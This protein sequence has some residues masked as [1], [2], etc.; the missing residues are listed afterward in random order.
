MER[1]YIKPEIYFTSSALE[2]LTTIESERALVITDPFMVQ[3]GFIDKLTQVLASS[4]SEYEVFSNIKP[5][6]P[7][8][9]VAEGVLK[10][11]HLNPEIVI[12]FGGG[13][14]IDAAKSII[15]LA[16]QLRG[17][18][19]KPKL[20]AI[21]TTSG[22]GSEVTSFSV[23]TV[24]DKKVPM[25]DDNLIPDVAILDPRFVTTAPPII[26]A[27]T[28]IDALTHAIEAYVST[29]ASD[30]TDAL[31]EKAVRLIFDYLL[32]AYKDGSNI[33]AREKMHN[34][35]C[36]AGMAF[37]NAYL[38]INHSMAHALGGGF[39]I[40]HGR[41][42]AI[43]LPYV[44]RYNAN[45]ES[46]IET[47]TAKRYAELARILH[48]PASSVSE[49]V[50]SLIYA[51]EILLK[52]TKTPLTISELNISPEEYHQKLESM[53]DNA[54][55]DKCTGTNPRIPTKDDIRNIYLN[56]YGTHSK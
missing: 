48:L 11:L 42:N 28:G 46:D 56:A 14:T 52:E 53:C 1:F 23:I 3:S 22:T 5:D 55:M 4:V 16:Q 40:S 45:L 31:A 24:G 51:V 17:E 33:V 27:D 8:E 6:P 47:E 7:V 38:G 37:T 34:A 29:G 19:I 43:L 41:A 10:M 2:Y 50:H 12:A 26:T 18:G 54:L 25:I 13:S 30:Y 35:S 39:H 20:I 44:I 15:A 9:V 49:G 36:I 32:T 21:P